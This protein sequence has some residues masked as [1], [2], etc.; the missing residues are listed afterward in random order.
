MFIEPCSLYL[1]LNLKAIFFE[2]PKYTT[3]AAWYCRIYVERLARLTINCC[4]VTGDTVMTAGDRFNYVNNILYRSPSWCL[5]FKDCSSVTEGSKR[6]VW[7]YWCEQSTHQSQLNF[8]HLSKPNIVF[9]RTNSILSHH[10]I[11]HCTC[12]SDMSTS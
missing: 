12:T 3:V 5:L 11:M 6:Q 10:H 7:L 8:R 9:T 4:M 2:K 1:R